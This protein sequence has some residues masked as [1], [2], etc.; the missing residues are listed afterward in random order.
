MDPSSVVHRLKAL[1]AFSSIG[2]I[3]LFVL[4]AGPRQGGVPP[5]PY[6]ANFFS[7]VITVQGQTPPAGIQIVGCVAD[8]VQIFESQPVLTDA[9][10]NYVA[11]ELNPVDEELVGRIVTFYLVNEFGRIAASETRRFEG[12]FNIY[13]LDLTFTDP[14]PVFTPAPTA[15]APNPTTLS[16]I[17]ETGLVTTVNGEGFAPNS[18]VTLTSG[19]MTLGTAPTDGT[20]AFRLVIAAPSSVAGEYEVTSTDEAGTSRNVTLTVP[21]LT[22]PKGDDGNPG[23]NGLPAQDGIDGIDGNQ[24]SA[25]PQGDDGSIILPVVALSLAGLGILIIIVIYLYLISWYKDLARRLPPPGIR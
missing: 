8:C 11:L 23:D 20:G 1:A 18:L 3:A 9:D 2:L 15:S 25:G 10:G 16:L 12:D 5:Q 19:G 14:V 4:G 17:P 22:G 13:D 24:G 21:D 6:G 7:G